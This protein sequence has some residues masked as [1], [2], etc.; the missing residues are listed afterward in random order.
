M[1]AAR[2]SSSFF[3]KLRSTFS[4]TQ[5]NPSRVTLTPVTSPAISMAKTGQTSVAST[6]PLD[7]L[8][9]LEAAIAEAEQFVWPEAT[10]PEVVRASRVVSQSPQLQSQTMGLGTPVLDTA[11]SMLQPQTTAELQSLGVD[12]AALESPLGAMAQAFPTVIAQQTNTLNPG[13][14]NSVPKETWQEAVLAA[15]TVEAVPTVE[16]VSFA[17]EIVTPETV[18]AASTIEQSAAATLEANAGGQYIEVEPM[19]PEIP[20]EVEGYLQE[21]KD[22]QDQLPQEIVIADNQMQLMPSTAQPLRPVVVLPISP[23]EEVMG[24]KKNP[25]W[26]LRWLVEWSRKLMKTFTGKIIYRQL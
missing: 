20:V 21:V 9:A 3:G 13:F 4:D 17:S 8:A 26:S 25:S 5:A 18:T 12:Q 1:S 10:A 24:A 15:P 7:H 19:A 2:S 23:E 16:V 22:H 14:V 6:E 11:T